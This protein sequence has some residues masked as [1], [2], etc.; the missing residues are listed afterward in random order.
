M[1]SVLDHVKSGLLDSRLDRD[2]VVSLHSSLKIMQILLANACC[3]R[4]CLRYIGCTDFRLYA[5]E[6][7][8]L[9]KAYEALFKEAE[10]TWTHPTTTD[11][12]CAA[13]LGSIQFADSFVDDVCTRLAEEDYKV[14]S[15]CLTCTLPVSILPRDHLMKVHVKNVLNAEGHTTKL[16][17]TWSDLAVRDPKDFFKYLF[18]MKLKEKTGLLLDVD[19]SLR[20]TVIIGHEP[21]S[22]EH[23][24][25]TELKEPLLNVRTVRQKKVRVTVGDSRSCIVEALKRLDN[26]EAK[27]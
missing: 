1:S 6:E 2:S 21:T 23:M 19:A 3:S 15:V 24:F 25:L 17:Q 22:K 13:C 16:A 8:E 20:M 27:E 10:L 4:C 11:T 12:I 7:E 26:E 14:D 9:L 5:Y 18:G